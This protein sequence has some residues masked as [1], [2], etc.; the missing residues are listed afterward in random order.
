MLRYAQCMQHACVILPRPQLL[1]QSGIVA[2]ILHGFS[3]SCG[4]CRCLRNARTGIWGGSCLQALADWMSH[5]RAQACLRLDR[6]ISADNWPINKSHIV[7][8]RSQS[9]TRQIRI[10]QDG[11]LTGNEWAAPIPLNLQF[12]AS[13]LCSGHLNELKVFWSFSQDAH[14][15]TPAVNGQFCSRTSH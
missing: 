7:R 4:H 12:A 3:S 2:T 9:S 11:G 1:K 15:F 8:Y 10:R 14:I 5:A 6:P 13:N